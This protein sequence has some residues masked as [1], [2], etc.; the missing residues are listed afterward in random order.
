MNPARKLDAEV[1][2]Q[3]LGHKVFVKSKKLFE[4]TE[5]GERP[6]RFFDTDL[7]D[8]WEVAEKLNISLIAVEDGGWFAFVGPRAWKSPTDLLE[9]IN[10]GQFEGCG[11]A[12]GK[13]PARVICHAAI[14]ATN[15]R[16]Q[17]LNEEPAAQETE[18]T[19]TERIAGQSADENPAET[20]H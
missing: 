7:N 14:N 3:V 13:S 10:A 1:A 18:H 6:L 11:A 20:R 12:V 16:N 4:Q 17:E 2:E 9:F 5:K 19:P 15:K 8:A